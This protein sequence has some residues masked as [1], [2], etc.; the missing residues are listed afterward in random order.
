MKC[1]SLEDINFISRLKIHGVS[2]RSRSIERRGPR[3]GSTQVMPDSQELRF[4]EGFRVLI[5]D[6]DS[7]IP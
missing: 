2:I 7:S 3:K 5:L 4:I 1:S 6:A